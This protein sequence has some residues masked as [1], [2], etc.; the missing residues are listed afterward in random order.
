[1]SQSIAIK[2]HSESEA[3]S[4]PALPVGSRHKAGLFKKN[5]INNYVKHIV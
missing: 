2:E 4:M 1:M 3:I 5:L